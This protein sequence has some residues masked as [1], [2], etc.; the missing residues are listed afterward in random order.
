[1]AF[2]R[3]TRVLTIRADESSEQVNGLKPDLSPLLL[4]GEILLPA[5]LTVHGQQK[6]KAQDAWDLEWCKPHI[7]H[8]DIHIELSTEFLTNRFGWFHKGTFTHWKHF[9]YRDWTNFQLH[10]HTTPSTPAQHRGFLSTSWMNW[11][12]HKW[13]DLH[14]KQQRIGFLSSVIPNSIQCISSNSLWSVSSLPCFRQAVA[15]VH[16]A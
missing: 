2:P 9:L 1:M 15:S 7:F 13:T 3:L 14:T 16:K 11:H 10:L 4:G 8:I 6:Q 5:T 12:V